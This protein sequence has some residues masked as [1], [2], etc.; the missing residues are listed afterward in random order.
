MLKAN[1][2][3]CFWYNLSIYVLNNTTLSIL[4][5][6]QKVLILLDKLIKLIKLIGVWSKLSKSIYDL[7]SASIY[8]FESSRFYSR[9][10]CHVND[11]C[12]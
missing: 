8:I 4:S 11:L 6:F 2:I 1:I 12:I 5:T 9:V 3:R 7:I 10:T